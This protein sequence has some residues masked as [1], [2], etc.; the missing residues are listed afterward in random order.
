MAVVETFKAS[1]LRYIIVGC[2]LRLAALAYEFGKVKQLAAFILGHGPHCGAARKIHILQ[3]IL[4]PGCMRSSATSRCITI[5]SSVCQ[6]LSKRLV[7]MHLI[8]LDAGPVKLP[9][10]VG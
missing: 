7:F 4:V 2:D 8:L 3:A 9:V 5:S 6:S 1:I 10:F